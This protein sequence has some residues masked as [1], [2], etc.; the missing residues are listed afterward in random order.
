MASGPFGDIQL[1]MPCVDVGR[2]ASKIESVSLK[3]KVRGAD[4]DSPCCKSVD[5]ASRC[6]LTW[7]LP[8][9]NEVMRVASMHVFEHAP[10]K[11]ALSSAPDVD[12]NH[13]NI[14]CKLLESATLVCALL[15]EHRCLTRLDVGDTSVLFLHFPAML[16]K[17]LQQNKGLK[18]VRVH[19]DDDMG[20]W[21]RTQSLAILCST[22]AKLSPRLDV[23]DINELLPTVESAGRVAEAL[24]R[25]RLQR[26]VISNGVSSKIAGTL[27]RAVASSSLRVLEIGGDMKLP[28][29]SVAILSQALKRNET[30][31]KL[32][33]EWANNATGTLLKSLKDNASLEELTLM[34]SCDEPNDNLRKGLK[35]LRSNRSLKCLKL[36]QVSLFDDS[37]IIIAGILR[38]NDELREVCLPENGISDNGARELAK[39]LQYNSTLKRL[40]ISKCSLSHEALSS[41]VESL[42]LNTTVECVRL[43]DI[44]IPETWTPSTPLTANVC[45]RLDVAWNS[46]GLEDWASSLRQGVGRRFPRVCVGWTKLAKSSAAVHWFD[47]ART[48]DVSFTELVINCPGR[49]ARECGDAAVSFL[50]ATSSLKKLTVDIADRSYSYVTAI[51]RGLARNTSVSEARFCQGL[52]ISQDVKA[53]RE[54]MRTNRTLY[55]LAFSA[56]FLQE[57]DIRTLGR[58]LED[59]FVLLSFDFKYPPDVGMYPILSILDRNRYILNR[60]V[61]CV[62]NSSVEEESIKALR[63]LSNADSLLDAV[64][65]VS[66]KGREEC[67]IL[68]Q[69]SVRRL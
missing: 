66:G 49:I 23:L 63:M 8:A 45:A 51:I 37:A 14:E 58:A 59:N 38:D 3:F 24:R 27:F 28:P 46:R 5:S 44:H 36:L 33:I 7:H 42:S 65:D 67:R 60:A 17:A 19:V 10:G 12:L 1:D 35:E 57:R 41:F 62:L 43:G 55:R 31:R 6:W 20:V 13:R 61:E 52:H 53:L 32:S 48:T 22:V 34:Y 15:K 47:A 69:G 50:E 26:L 39:A 11:L 18:E 4:L 54:L 56:H 21:R 64:A 16:C 68:V 9:V 25:G 29:S 30:L 2:L 40:D